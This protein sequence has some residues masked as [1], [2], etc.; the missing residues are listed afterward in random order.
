MVA[1]ATAE[2]GVLGSIS[3]SD[4]LFSAHVS[5]VGRN[6]HSDDFPRWHQKKTHC[7][8]FQTKKLRILPF[9]VTD[10]M[11]HNRRYMPHS[12]VNTNNM[13][14]TSL[15]YQFRIHSLVTNITV[16]SQFSVD[17]C[18]PFTNIDRTERNRLYWGCMRHRCAD[19]GNK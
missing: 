2:Q 17:A 5:T 7:K 16:S 9:S 14:H 3:E 11:Q 10:K 19:F 15:I 12:Y 18:F 13:L 1:S 6:H 8:H 4:K